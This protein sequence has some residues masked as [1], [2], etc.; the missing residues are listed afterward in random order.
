MP[1]QGLLGPLFWLLLAGLTQKEGAFLVP[2]V[3]SVFKNT[4]EITAHTLVGRR[5][6]PVVSCH[7]AVHQI[8]LLPGD[9]AW[10]HQSVPA[11][12]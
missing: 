1:L 7:T 5:P 6:T 3:I 8:K 4:P 2:C 12:K 10:K 9:R 11:W